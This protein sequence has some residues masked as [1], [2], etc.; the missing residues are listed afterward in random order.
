MDSYLKRMCKSQF[1]TDVIQIN[2]YE[3]TFNQSSNLHIMRIETVLSFSTIYIFN[4]DVV[5]V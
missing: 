3:K 1:I 5:I 4:H 2:D